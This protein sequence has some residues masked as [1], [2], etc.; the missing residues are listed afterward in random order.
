MI[1]LSDVEIKKERLQD[2]SYLFTGNLVPI[3]YHVSPRLLSKDCNFDGEKYAH[4]YVYKALWRKLY[5][6][7]RE[8]IYRLHAQLREMETRLDPSKI[9][10]IEQ[11]RQREQL[12][13]KLLTLIGER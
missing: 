3:S 13:H 5:G 2:G 1:Q 9:D 8:P 10:P 6:D 7:L 12:I 11:H 4:E